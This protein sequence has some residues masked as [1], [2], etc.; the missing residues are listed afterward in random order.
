MCLW[1][2]APVGTVQDRTPLVPPTGVCSPKD[3]KFYTR[4]NKQHVTHWKL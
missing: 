4:K 2:C 1:L 3:N